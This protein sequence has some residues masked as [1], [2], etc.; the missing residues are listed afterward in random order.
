[1]Q[2]FRVSCGIICN[3]LLAQY[4]RPRTS[5]CVTAACVLPKLTTIPKSEAPS[6][7][8]TSNML[9]KDPIPQ[10]FSLSMVKAAQ[11]NLVMSL[12]K[13]YPSVHT[14]LLNVGGAVSK[15][16]SYLNP[17]AIAGKFWELYSQEKGDWTK[18]M[19]VL[20]GKGPGCTSTLIKQKVEIQRCTS[21]RLL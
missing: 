8:V 10:M 6:F 21:K 7:F 9:W 1:V 20:G 3:Y 11:R 4:P 15:D 12:Q 13:T 2:D 17:N 18:D 5:P 16:D 19:D 14:A